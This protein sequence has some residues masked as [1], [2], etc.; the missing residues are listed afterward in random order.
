VDELRNGTPLDVFDYI[1]FFKGL[2]SMEV[3]ISLSDLD[4]LTDFEA[5]MFEKWL[6]FMLVHTFA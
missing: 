4:Y 1:V 3:D 2:K 6:D 5:P